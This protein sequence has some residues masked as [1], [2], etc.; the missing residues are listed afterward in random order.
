MIKQYN[1][2]E[3]HSYSIEGDRGN[4]LNKRYVSIALLIAVILAGFFVYSMTMKD[5]RTPEGAK[6]YEVSAANINYFMNVAGYLAKPT[7]RGQYPSVVMIHEWWG[8]NDHI[9]DMARQLASEGYTVLAVDLYEGEVATTPE[10]ARQLTSSMDQERATRN[11][12][13]AVAYLREK[14]DAKKMASLGWCF[15][16]G[17]SLQLALSGEKLD[18]TV[19]YYGSL[20]TGEAK[21]SVIKWPVLGIFGDKDT[22]IPVSKVKEFN[23]AL[24]KLGIKNQIYIYQGVGH[25]FANPSGDNYASN[26]AKDAWEKT[27]AFLNEHLKTQDKK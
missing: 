19:I 12:R 27:V 17:Q 18:A 13:S 14:E 3:P 11:M 15:G 4:M 16:G 8:L 2:G 25:A 1:S 23:S 20:V 7:E 10:R 9:K 22:S 24:D 5:L 26:E 6:K 21:L